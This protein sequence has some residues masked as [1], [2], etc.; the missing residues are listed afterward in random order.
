M[1]AD[2]RGAQRVMVGNRRERNNMEDLGIDGRLI[3]KWI[4]KK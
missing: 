3:L 2:K 1:Y 4:L